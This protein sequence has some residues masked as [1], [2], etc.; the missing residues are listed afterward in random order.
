MK[1]LEV[2]DN[3]YRFN[4]EYSANHIVYYH[5]VSD[6][7][8]HYKVGFRPLRDDT[9]SVAFGTADDTVNLFAKDQER[10]V[11]ESSFR[12]LGTV[13]A[14]MR[15]YLGQHP[16]LHAFHFSID[17]SVDVRGSLEGVYNKMIDRLVP[18]N[19]SVRFLD[20]GDSQSANYLVTLPAEP[21][22]KRVGR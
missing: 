5:F 12:V 10:S 14:A 4:V 19:W 18:A 16:N 1:L 2:F 17:K 11:A 22:T 7:E 6:N 21:Q 13:V 8:V 3:P 20:T 9:V 15:D